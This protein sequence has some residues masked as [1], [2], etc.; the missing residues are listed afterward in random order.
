[1]SPGNHGDRSPATST[2]S[3]KSGPF[4]SPKV[5]LPK[6]SLPKGEAWVVRTSRGRTPSMIGRS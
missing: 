3:R 5:S 2:E 1:M 4:D 6:V